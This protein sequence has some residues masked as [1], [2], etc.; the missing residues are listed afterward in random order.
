MR[1]PYFKTNDP[2]HECIGNSNIDELEAKDR[3]YTIKAQEKGLPYYKWNTDL[4][5]LMIY[6]NGM[7]DNNEI[8][9][10]WGFMSRWLALTSKFEED[11]KIQYYAKEFYEGRIHY[12]DEYLGGTIYEYMYY[13]PSPYLYAIYEEYLENKGKEMPS[14]ISLL[15]DFYLPGGAIHKKIPSENGLS[16]VDCTSDDAKKYLGIYMSEEEESRIR[17]ESDAKLKAWLAERQ[18]CDSNS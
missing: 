12:T 3:E 13:G 15:R 14:Y 9:G 5:T 1:H 11:E 17:E 10:L 7:D 4:M 2:L 6:Q 16:L 8:P 18:G